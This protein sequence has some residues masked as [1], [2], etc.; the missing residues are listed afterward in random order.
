MAKKNMTMIEPF[1]KQGTWWKPGQDNRV[2]GILRF[3]P[4][5]GVTVTL[6]QPF[7]VEFAKKIIVHQN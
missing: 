4:K 5:N 2:P 3:D 6:F 7:D 1:E